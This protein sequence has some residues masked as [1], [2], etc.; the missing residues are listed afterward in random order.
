M[1]KKQERGNVKYRL[2]G[3]DQTVHGEAVCEAE[4][5]GAC[6]AEFTADAQ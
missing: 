2:G 4:K 6:R 3:N 5:R 1:Q